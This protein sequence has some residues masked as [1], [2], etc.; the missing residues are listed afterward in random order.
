[1]TFQISEY[2]QSSV[3]KGEY[4]LEVGQPSPQ[5]LP[6]E[7]FHSAFQNDIK[8]STF[9]Q[10]SYK[11]GYL[12]FRK[13]LANFLASETGVPVS[14]EALMITAGNSSAIHLIAT[15]LVSTCD[16]PP[17]AVV[18]SPTYRFA[19]EILKVCGFK[20]VEVPVDKAGFVVEELERFL[21]EEK[22]RPALVFT[23]PAFHNPTGVTLTQERRQK[24]IQLAFDYHFVIIADEAYQ[25]LNYSGNYCDSAFANEDTTDNGVVF[26]LGTFSKILAPGIRLGWIQARPQLL[27]ELLKH[28]VLA[29]G[30]GMNS[31]MAGWIEPLLK[32]DSL[33]SHLNQLRQVL[34]LRCERLYQ[35]IQHFL[36]QVTIITQPKGGYFIWCKLP[37]NRDSST[38]CEIAKSQYNVSF[39]AGQKCNAS[40]D[41]FRLCF[42]FYTSEELEKAIELLALAYIKLIIDN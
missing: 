32:N 19:T 28:P 17:V 7:L 10:Y 9:L 15:M 29:S 4:H 21:V 27:K 16:A 3:P 37:D 14:E 26:T 5:L 24:L 12:S 33:Q 8:D 11:Q 6:L 25:L 35:A 1:M 38:L 30:G 20:L 39:L 2:I 31:V 41:Y 23:I 18:E 13:A 42:A 22:L 40:S 34:A 36:P